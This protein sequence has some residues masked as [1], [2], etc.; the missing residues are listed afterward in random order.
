ME[1]MTNQEKM[2]LK[3]FS[4][5]SDE[6]L[7]HLI[8]VKSILYSRL[9]NS[10]EIARKILANHGRTFYKR[11]ESFK[12]NYFKL[13]KCAALRGIDTDKLTRKTKA[14]L[15]DIISRIEENRYKEISIIDEYCYKYDS[16]RGNGIWDERTSSSYKD[17]EPLGADILIAEVSELYDSII[18]E[19]NKKYSQDSQSTKTK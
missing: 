16:Y 17:N 15:N 9:I 19:V 7:I 12:Y 5:F 11:N 14:S 1:E 18:E 13:L 3:A 6:E 2:I 8:E 10:E 4:E